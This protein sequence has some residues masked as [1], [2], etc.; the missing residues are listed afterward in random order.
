LPVREKKKKVETE[1]HGKLGRPCALAFDLEHRKKVKRMWESCA[2]K[3]TGVSVPNLR[4]HNVRGN[5]K[6]GRL[7]LHTKTT[8]KA[9]G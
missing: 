9:T 8:E 5:S 6:R 2:A 1:T 3:K 7:A 4:S